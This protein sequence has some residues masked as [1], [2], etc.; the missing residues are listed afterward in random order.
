MRTLQRVI[1]PKAAAALSLLLAAS[2]ARAVPVSWMAL[3]D[4]TSVGVGA[5]GGGGYPHRL[6]RRLEGSG[7]RVRL[8]VL[9]TSG[10]TAADL[11]RDQLPRV[12][13]ARPA[14]VT[15]GIGLNDAVAGR[16]LAQFARD[17]EVVADLV[18]RTDAAVVMATVPDVSLVPAAQ[19]GPPGL[20]RRIA[21]YNASIRMVAE[22][23]GFTVA[24]VHG[25]TRRALAERPDVVARDGFH[26]SAAGYEL[27]ADAM[28]PAVERALGPR[29]H[30]RR[31]PQ[32]AER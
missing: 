4:S 28:W 12:L 29:V 5:D 13:S 21:A 17:L 31:P 14:L 30:A 16:P 6:A 26:P 11:R 10:A 19:G 27:W 18:R 15:I 2:A 32:P 20:S 7:V 23:H 3:G 8:Q 25:A 22:R 9:G 24:D 1:A